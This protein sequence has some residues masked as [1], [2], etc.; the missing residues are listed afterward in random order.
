MT[1]DAFDSGAVS[2]AVHRARPDVIVNLLTDLSTGD[3]ASNARLRIVGTRHLVDAA[4]SAGTSRIVAESISWVYSPGSAPADEDESL[5]PD[6]EEPRRTTIAAVTALE[7]AVSEMPEHVVLR[8][9]QLY[10]PGTW[11]SRDGR[12][13]KDA[14]AARLAATETVVSFIHTT[15]AVRAI[16]LALDWENGAWNI[17]DDEPASGH[18]WVPQFAAAVGA[19]KPIALP[20]SGIIGR[21][22]S[23]ARAKNRG[24]VLKYPSWREGFREL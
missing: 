13:G 5:D 10:G 19:P 16:L 12:L 14:Q 9:G 11:Y 24:L 23:N 3:S 22:V 6:P 8:F 18:K 7:S 1:L 15:D 4:V 2:S 20:A 21:P 17:V